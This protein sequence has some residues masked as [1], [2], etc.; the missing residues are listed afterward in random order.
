MTNLYWIL[1]KKMLTSPFHSEQTQIV[2][3]VGLELATSGDAPTSA[4]QSA[5]ITGVSHCSRPNN[6]TFTSL[7]KFFFKSNF[8]CNTYCS[9]TCW[10]HEELM[11][12]T[13]ISTWCMESNPVWIYKLCPANKSI[14]TGILFLIIFSN[15]DSWGCMN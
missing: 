1:P 2:I 15:K 8:T 9:F 11:C 3:Q 7:S 13:F 12:L 4:F 14:Y 5:G 10:T 6:S